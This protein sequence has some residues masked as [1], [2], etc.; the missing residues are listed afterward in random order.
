IAGRSV[1]VT[2]ASKGIGKGLARVFA[3]KG[4]KV[5]VVSRNLGNARKVALE[6]RE[7]GG[8]AEA[9]SADVSDPGGVRDM[10]SA[11]R[12]CHGGIDIL[13]ANAGIYPMGKLEEMTL[14]D[15]ENVLRTNLTGTYLSVAACL[16]DLKRS[17]RGR[18][19][20]TSSISG[21]VTAI[22][23]LSHYGASKAG[24]VGFMRAA[25]LELASSGITV[26][27]IL[28]GNIATEGVDGLGAEYI[29]QM[30][31]AIPLR[32]LGT[33]EEVA[34]AALFLASDEAAYIT[35]Q[36][37]TV[38]GGQLLPESKSAME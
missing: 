18:I 20:I 14:Q 19:V 34:Y 15:W 36:T 22:S 12:E 1:I 6:I 27:A 30:T 9:F 33:V 16:P 37:I 29:S 25:A 7:R 11:A 24:Q 17:G 5:L 4:C 21:P 26:N 28:P 23:G 32:R 38:D 8:I 35:G 13:C 2:G 10:A 3:Q 31:S